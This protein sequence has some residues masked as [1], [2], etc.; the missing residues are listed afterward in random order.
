VFEDS[1]QTTC[2]LFYV[3]RYCRSDS[4]PYEI[5]YDPSDLPEFADC[6][7]RLLDHSR[8]FIMEGDFD[9]QDS[10]YVFLDTLDAGESRLVE[11]VDLSSSLAADIRITSPDIWMISSYGDTLTDLRTTVNDSV[12]IYADF[13]NLGTVARTNVTTLLYYSTGTD[14]LGLDSLS[15]IGL[16]YTPDS[17]CRATDMQTASFGWRPDSIGAHRMTV[18][19]PPGNGEPNT[20]D[21]LVEFVFLVD[22]RDYATDV[23]G[24]AW[25][26]D[27]STSIHAWHTNDIDTIG[28]NW[29]TSESA[30]TDS[31]SGMFEGIV[32]YDSLI[33][34][35]FQASISLVISDDTTEYIDPDLYHMFSLGVTVNNPNTTNNIGCKLYMRWKDSEGEWGCNWTNVLYQTGHFVLNGWDRWR[36]V[37]PVDLSQ[38]TGLNWGDDNVSELWLK[39]EAEETLIRPPQPINVRIGWVRLEE[40][41]P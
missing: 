32:Q 6:S 27:D 9:K 19:V 22:P 30:W 40:S 5:S 38:T 36:A 34:P 23:L 28:I 39:I 1:A 7:T 35:E 41:A 21:N 13:Y 20:D 25:D 11:L 10:V 14:T 8:R 29:D 17:L 4:N 26:M 12:T 3:D 37:G 2:Y 18:S 15:F 31:V 16:S 24:E 33:D